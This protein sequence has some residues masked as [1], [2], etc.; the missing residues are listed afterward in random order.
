MKNPD[1]GKNFTSEDEV[2]T[3]YS[4]KFTDGVGDIRTGIGWFFDGIF[5]FPSRGTDAQ[6]LDPADKNNEEKSFSFKVKATK[7]SLNKTK[8]SVNVGKSAKVKVKKGTVK[9][10]SSSN[11]KIVTVKDGKIKG[12]KRGS[13]KVTATLFSGRKLSVKVNVK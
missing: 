7:A 2:L 11:N 5:Y 1:T 12:V 13:A 8:V 10:W 3:F 6:V 4:T 9:K